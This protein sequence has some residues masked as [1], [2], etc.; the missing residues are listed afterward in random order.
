MQAWL[1][2]WKNHA[3]LVR[4][5]HER[6]DGGATCQAAKDAEPAF[7]TVPTT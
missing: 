6:A 3:H 4:L 2:S 7:E 1:P 5:Q